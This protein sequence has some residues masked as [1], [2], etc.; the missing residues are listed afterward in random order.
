M[1]SIVTI[2]L[3]SICVFE[4][5]KSDLRVFCFK[6]PETLLHLFCYCV[7]VGKFWNDVSDW[8]DDTFQI[9]FRF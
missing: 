8:I 1:R 4:I 7:I 6:S 2:P 5:I 3:T 9:N